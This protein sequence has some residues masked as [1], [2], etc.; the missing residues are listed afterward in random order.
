VQRRGRKGSAELAVVSIAGEQPRPAPPVAL[1]D[2]EKHYWR[3]IVG[4]MPSNWFPVET[5]PLLTQLC[6]VTATSDETGLQ[7]NEMRRQGLQ[8]T[9]DFQRL[10]NLQLTQ[11]KVLMNLA[12]KMRLTQ[13][14][15][16]DPQT[17]KKRSSTD[18]QEDPW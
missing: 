14:S 4:H 11:A 6:R 18:D 13:Q 15:T 12:T 7:M 2:E 1:S 8:N 10:A 9:E 5:W 17:S 16:Y 3:E